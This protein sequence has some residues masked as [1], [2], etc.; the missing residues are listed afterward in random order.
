MPDPFVEQLRELCQKERT[1]AKWVIVPSQGLGWTLGE[2]LLHEGRD[3]LNLRFV[4]PF[5]LALESAAPALIARGLNP[6][7]E[8]LGPSLIQSLVLKHKLKDWEPL[9][10]QPGMAEA[11]WRTLTECRMAGVAPKRHKKLFQAYENYLATNR[12]ADRAT[13]LQQPL[14]FCPIG[15]DDLVLPY[16]YTVW[17]PL[18]QKLI[19]T[20]KG[21][22]LTPHATTEKAPK[23]YLKRRPTPTPTLEPVHFYAGRRE[24]E[25]AEIL[26]RI[27]KLDQAE[28]AAERE[29]LPLLA[30]QGLPV[31]FEEGLPFAL[32][33]PGQALDGLLEWVEKDMPA[34]HLRELILSGL[35][36]APPGAARLLEQ[37][38]ITWGRQTYLARLDELAAYAEARATPEAPWRQ[39]QADEARGLAA[40]MAS[41]FRRLPA[42]DAQ[43]KIDFARWIEGLQ[44]L[45]STRVLDDLKLLAEGRWP[46]DQVLRLV[47]Q[48]LATRTWNASRPRPGALHVTSLERLGLS[49]R[50]HL[51]VLG[52]EEGRYRSIPTE[53]CVLDDAERTRLKLPTSTERAAER[54]FAIRERMATLSGIVTFSYAACDRAGDQEQ[55]PGAWFTEKDPPFCFR[56]PRPQPPPNR[57]PTTT[58]F[59]VYDGYV[60]SAAGKWANDPLSASRLQSLATCP[61]RFFLEKGLGLTPEPLQLPDPD[62]WLDAATRGTV[63]HEVFAAYYRELRAKGWRPEPTRDRRFLRQL[64][65]RQLQAL[66]RLLPPPSKAIQRAET[67]ELKDELDR[68]LT[69]ELQRPDRLPIACEVP[70]GMDVDSP[71]PLARR[72]PVVLDLG[73][74]TIA[75]RG[76][77]DR[78][79]QL[80]DGFGVVD[81]KTGRKLAARRD[82]VFDRGRLLQHALYAVVAEE[83]GK[84]PVRESAYYFPGTGAAR[85]W[86]AYGPPDRERLLRVLTLVTE[87][88]RSGAFVHTHESTRDCTY[89]EYKAA[90][91]GH[92]DDEVRAKLE[93]PLLAS[94]RQLL[95]EE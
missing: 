32:S 2:R 3:W 24:D 19:Q 36:E 90:C 95:G 5:R 45:T 92:R 60:P 76:Q 42:P 13:V 54:H 87:P 49:G 43:R 89:C 38:K 94:R 30:R 12:L 78:L 74:N 77:L 56:V 58:E 8:N 1:A 29:D 80:P 53:D 73:G 46:Q 23:R 71:E 79:D 33:K 82:A 31:T 59:T 84:G 93:D 20:I 17:A 4:T 85:E 48:H 14:E 37:A 25:I 9:I 15:P 83:L 81:Y 44:E 91:A 16:P 47:R 35:L 34:F 64:L 50:P 11:L 26:K 21:Q 18:E 28:L 63:L 10:L 68:F 61:F 57:R 55:L 72:E 69:L 6:T 7:P 75:L 65:E 22:H 41:V 39:Q 27:P 67:E 70:F 51:F 40:W 66:A 86:I 52:L 88:L 62:R